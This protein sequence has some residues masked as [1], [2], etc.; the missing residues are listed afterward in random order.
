MN[1]LQENTLSIVLNIS[2][3]EY[4]E[5][6]HLC[7]LLCSKI[8]IPVL[9]IKVEKLEIPKCSTFREVDKL[10]YTAHQLTSCIPAQKVLCSLWLPDRVLT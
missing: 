3:K 7:K 2:L 8:F 4:A 10:L 5:Y 9:F 1:S 6:F